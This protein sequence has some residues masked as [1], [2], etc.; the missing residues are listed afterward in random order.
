MEMRT[1]NQL[2][3]SESVTGEAPR[4]DVIPQD[5][6]RHGCTQFTCDAGA[7][8]ECEDREAGKIHKFSIVEG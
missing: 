6:G 1:G 7:V 2:T 8:L 3:T 4:P 5:V